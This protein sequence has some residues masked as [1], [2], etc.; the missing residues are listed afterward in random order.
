MTCFGWWPLVR[1][2]VR[3]SM[4]GPSAA[5][6]REYWSPTKSFLK[7]GIVNENNMT[8]CILEYYQ[9]N[10]IKYCCV[11]WNLN[12]VIAVVTSAPT[13]FGDACISQLIN[14]ASRSTLFPTKAS[15]TSFLD[16]SCHYEFVGQSAWIQLLGSSP[17]KPVR[18]THRHCQRNPA[19]LGFC[20]WKFLCGLCPKVVVTQALTREVTS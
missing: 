9:M 6:R 11:S 5:E 1:Q 3:K 18:P 4:G 13:S 15:I 17:P 10:V 8:I 20:R 19:N 2:E 14:P 7:K 12:T 16:L